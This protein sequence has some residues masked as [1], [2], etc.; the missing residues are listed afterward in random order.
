MRHAEPKTQVE[1]EAV[2]A[3]LDAEWDKLDATGQQTDKVTREMQRIR[4]L[5]P[6]LPEGKLPNPLSSP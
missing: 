6:S 4:N 1:A 3:E 5:L 2:L